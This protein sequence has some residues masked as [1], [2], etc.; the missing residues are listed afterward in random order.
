MQGKKR[1]GKGIEI[2]FCFV[3]YYFLS[4]YCNRKVVR[5]R[6][7]YCIF[8]CCERPVALADIQLRSIDPSNLQIKNPSQSIRTGDMEIEKPIDSFY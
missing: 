8:F 6:A 4:V 5:A 3:I 7:T 2:G 1:G